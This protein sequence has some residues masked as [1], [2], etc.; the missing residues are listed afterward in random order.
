M[1]QEFALSLCNELGLDFEF[2]CLI[3]HSIR[4]QIQT[5]QRQAIDRGLADF[6]AGEE[7][8]QMKKSTRSLLESSTIVNKKNLEQVLITEDNYLRNVGPDM[9]NPHDPNDVARWEP[10]IE[11]LDPEEIAR[12]KKLED[13]K[14]R[15]LIILNV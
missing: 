8:M 2:M 3:A 6:R 9:G 12:I 13:R 1:H 15:Y 11:V 14:N 5:H 7:F 4:E 10:R